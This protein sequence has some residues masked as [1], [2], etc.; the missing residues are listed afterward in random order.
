MSGLTQL[1]G[2]DN[3]LLYLSSSYVFIMMSLFKLPNKFIITSSAYQN[4]FYNIHLTEQL[5]VN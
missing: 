5:C 1:Q 3:N 2:S 4:W